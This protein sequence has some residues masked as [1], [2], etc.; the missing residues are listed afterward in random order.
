MRLR[1]KFT[2]VCVR[3]A[4]QLLQH[5]L[6]RGLSFHHWIITVLLSTVRWVCLSGVYFWTLCCTDLCVYAFT[7]TTP[8]SL[9]E[10]FYSKFF[11]FCCLFFCFLG[12]HLWH[13]EVPRL[14]VESEL[15]L[16]VYT[17][18]TATWG[19]SRICSLRHGSWQHRILNWLSEARDWNCILMDPSRVHDHWATKG[20]PI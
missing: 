13:M 7:N 18:A 4:V 20:T 19:L 8:S 10:K 6:L 16:P 11:G 1:L 17:T 2:C 14:G 12:L 5:H 9:L 3:V 15:Q